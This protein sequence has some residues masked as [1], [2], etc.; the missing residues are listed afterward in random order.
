[1]K[2]FIFLLNLVFIYLNSDA[3]TQLWSTTQNGGFYANGGT[4]FKMDGSGNNQS[5]EFDFLVNDCK[6]PTY[7]DLIEASDGS[8]Y[9]MSK[10]GGIS[11]SGVLFQYNPVTNVYTKKIDFDL[12]KG[13]YPEASLIQAID[14]KLYGMTSQGGTNNVGVLF[15]FDPITN[16]YTKKLDFGNSLIGSFPLG[17]LIQA[18]DGNLYGLTNC[19]SLTSCGVYLFLTSYQLV[20]QCL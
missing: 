8:F 11:N 9:A 12:T 2:Q 20:I 14:G 6:N 16:V 7:S 3:Q 10:F 19:S 15:Q 18:S 13:T 4:I 5:V 17:S 1:M